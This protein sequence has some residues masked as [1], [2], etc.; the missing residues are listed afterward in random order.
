MNC[1]RPRSHF[2]LFLSPEVPWLP[3]P[4]QGADHPIPK[5]GA[6]NNKDESPF[7]GDCG[8]PITVKETQLT[9]LDVDT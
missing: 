1:T 3:T 2:A 9:G 8:V 7:E 5:L 6:Q 4:L